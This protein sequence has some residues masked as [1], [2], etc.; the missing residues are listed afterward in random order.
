MGFCS[1][2]GEP[3]TLS[4]SAF[5]TNHTIICR[6][7][8]YV[9]GAFIVLAAVLQPFCFSSFADSSGDGWSERRSIRNCSSEIKLPSAQEDDALVSYYYC[10][11]MAY[12][13][14]KSGY[15]PA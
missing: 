9:L 12:A 11:F 13:S 6:S 2:D 3:V 7:A 14:L 4:H 15:A 8:R 10:C 1:D 5:S